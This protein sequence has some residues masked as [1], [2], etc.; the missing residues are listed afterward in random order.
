MSNISL[1]LINQ[2]W[3]KNLFNEVPIQVFAHPLIRLIVLFLLICRSSLFILHRS[4]LLKICIENLFCQ[5]VAAFSFTLS[6]DEQKFLIL[7]NYSLLTF[8]F[9][10]NAFCVPFK[11]Y[12]PSQKA[13]SPV[14]FSRN[15]LVVAGGRGGNVR[16]K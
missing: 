1:V 16:G 7:V 12:L 9:M 11:E 6:S 3:G 5:S 4:S 14:F 2:L 13:N 10:V 8:Y 15:I